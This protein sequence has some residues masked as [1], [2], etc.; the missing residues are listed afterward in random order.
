[1]KISELVGRTHY[2][3]HNWPDWVDETDPDYLVPIAQ[4]KE[5]V[6]ILVAGGEGRHSSWMAGWGVTRMQSEEIALI[7]Q[8]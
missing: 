4:S 2:C 5:D 3:N 1:M 6:V 7:K 8:K